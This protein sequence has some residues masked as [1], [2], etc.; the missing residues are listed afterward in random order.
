MLGYANLL[1]DHN[2]NIELYALA[3]ST[4][5]GGSALPAR[6]A[7]VRFYVDCALARSPIAPDADPASLDDTHMHR[8]ETL[9]RAMYARLTGATG[10]APDRSEAWNATVTGIQ[11]ALT[12]AASIK[13]VVVAP[14]IRTILDVLSRGEGIAADQWQALEFA[15]LSA[16]LQSASQRP[17]HNID[18][19][20]ASPFARA[21]H[22]LARAAE[23]LLM[24]SRGNDL[25]YTEIAY[26]AAHI[27]AEAQLWPAADR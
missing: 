13:E 21:H 8:L 6:E 22:N 18:S 14:E 20:Q 19:G 23:L 5:H 25:P 7:G 12:R 17:G 1:A 15:H 24:W 10:S 27:M 9:D 16:I 3:T 11:T 2:P 4:D 26:N